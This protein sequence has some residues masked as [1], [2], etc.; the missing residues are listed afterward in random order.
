VVKFQNGGGEKNS[1]KQNKHTNKTTLL[2]CVLFIYR[3]SLS[4]Y[5]TPYA[6]MA[7]HSVVTQDELHESEASW[8]SEFCFDNAY[9][10]KSCFVDDLVRFISPR[11]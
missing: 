2:C 8:A 11:L 3:K 7:D 10:E 1:G 6:N 5:H 9:P 4:Q